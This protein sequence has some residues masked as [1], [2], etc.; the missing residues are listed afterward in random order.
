MS[1]DNT[2]S[3]DTIRITLLGDIFPGELSFTEGYGIKSQFENHKGKPWEKSIKSITGENDLII[4]NLESPLI[5]QKEIIKETFHGHPDFATFLKNSGIN[6]VNI[7]NNHILEQSKRGFNSTLRILNKESVNYVGNEENGGSRIIYQ[8]VNGIEIAIAGFSSVDLQVIN[9]DHDFAILTESNVISS[10]EEMSIQ[11]ADVKI[12]CFHWG[13]EYVHIPSLDQRKMAYK[14][15]DAGADIIAGHHSH[16]IQPYEKY[17][18]G[19]IFYSLGNFMFDYL[20]SNMVRMGLVATIEI[21]KNKN[22]S[23]SLK[24]VKL[25]YKDTVTLLPASKFMKFYGNITELY[26]DF[27]T[28]PDKL[29]IERY[30]KMHRKNRFQRRLAMKAHIFTE[31]FIISP[32][33]KARLLKNVINYYSLLLR[34]ALFGKE[35]E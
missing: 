10:I 21:D 20:H 3:T 33:D 13:N 16:V 12:L 2:S 28:L 7:A 27:K 34:G 29:Y 9:N 15:I 22:L 24:G 4:G 32:K 26:D 11:K 5:S 1:K 17:K 19:H 18:N 6:I 30:Q 35:N 23:V 14:F 8:T 25:S 31:F